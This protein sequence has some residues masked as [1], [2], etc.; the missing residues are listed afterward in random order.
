MTH[1]FACKRTICLSTV[2]FVYGFNR[3]TILYNPTSFLVNTL[4]FLSYV[5]PTTKKHWMLG[6]AVVCW[7]RPLVLI[8]LSSLFSILFFFLLPGL[9]SVNIGLPNPLVRHLALSHWIAVIRSFVHE[10]VYAWVRGVSV[11]S[12]SLVNRFRSQSFPFGNRNMYEWKSSHI[13][14][15]YLI[16]LD[17]L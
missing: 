3:F 2:R 1:L 4:N 7:F 10:S 9:F 15:D 11:I 5:W 6:I 8:D 14:G 12:R 13:R 17:S 16:V